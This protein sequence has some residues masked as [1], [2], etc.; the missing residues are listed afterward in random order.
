MELNLPFTAAHIVLLL[1]LAALMV[2]WVFS[3]DEEVRLK[4]EMPITILNGLLDIIISCLIMNI[5]H[6]SRK[7]RLTNSL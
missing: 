6:E 2:W 4:I 7:V 3:S 1:I 5:V